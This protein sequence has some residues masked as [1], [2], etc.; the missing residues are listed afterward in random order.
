MLL[1]NVI[2]FTN[3]I[4]NLRVRGILTEGAKGIAA[5]PRKNMKKI[6]QMTKKEFVVFLKEL[7]S[8]LHGKS[9][10]LNDLRATEKVDGQAV[11]LGVFN[12]KIYVESS[13][14]GL[15]FKVSDLT[16]P[17]HIAL[18]RYCKKELA[19][20]LLS[21]AEA[22]GDFKVIGELFYIDNPEI[23][24]DDGTVTFVSTKYDAE[25][26]GQ[27]G[28]IV[29]FNAQR[30]EDE[31]PVNISEDDANVL[32][33]AVK[34]LSDDQFAIYSSNDISWKNTIELN[35]DLNSDIFNNP[36]ILLSSGN[37]EMFESFR[38]AV[39]KAFSEQIN[40]TGSVLG[41][42]GSVVE[43]IVFEI[44]GNKYGATNFNWKKMHES[45]Y[46]SEKDMQNAI[47]AFYKD[48]FGTIYSK[49][50]ALA[51]EEDREK[52][53]DEYA[54]KLPALKEKLGDIMEE[55]KANENLPKNIKAKLK[56]LLIIKLKKFNNLTSN[57]SSLYKMI[58]KKNLS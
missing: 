15:A 38:D 6:H 50:V 5:T 18:L 33:N 26:F 54:D 8:K 51:I 19:D 24:D 27:Q 14:S 32:I 7:K 36:D 46:K 1:K 11:R 28:G 40:N 16:Q 12:G 56:I 37:K 52:Y 43:G 17:G 10:D 13:N 30:I 42:P 44:N 55:F 47:D 22:F 2:K 21:I 20:K 23:I 35:F 39:A 3:K 45:Q 58:T 4:L 53:Q 57:I 34:S 49:K 29:L 25:K 48:I 9:L 41:I 31:R